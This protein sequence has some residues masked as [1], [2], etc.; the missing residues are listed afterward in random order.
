MK[1]ALYAMQAVLELS[2]LHVGS[3]LCKPVRE[4]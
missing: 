3:V 2:N 4:Q 1:D